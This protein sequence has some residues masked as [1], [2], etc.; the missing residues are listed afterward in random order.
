MTLTIT[1]EANPRSFTVVGNAAPVI[2]IPV[3][4]S[5]EVCFFKE[6]RRILRFRFESDVVGGDYQM[7]KIVAHI[8]ETDATYLGATQ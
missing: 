4:P 3:E 7:G 1:G 8:E 5:D 2:A 6:Q